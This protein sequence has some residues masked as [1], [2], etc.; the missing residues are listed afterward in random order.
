MH[1]V[2]EGPEKVLEGLLLPPRA[3]GCTGRR[4]VHRRAMGP[5]QAMHSGLCG[6]L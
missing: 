2:E 4:G 1:G 6:V 3:V 5:K